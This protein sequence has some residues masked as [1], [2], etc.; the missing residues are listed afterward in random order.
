[1]AKEVERELG[2]REK[3]VPKEVRECAVDAG[4]D[5]QEVSLEGADCLLG[6]VAAMHVWGKKLKSALPDLGDD[7]AVEG[8]V[9]VVKDLVLDNVAVTL[10]VL[11]DALVGSDAMLIVAALEGLDKD[12]I[13]VAMVS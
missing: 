3:L 12:G 6:D 9:L 4:E 13:G 11:H 10:E 8:A 5:A 2:L 7:L 1:M